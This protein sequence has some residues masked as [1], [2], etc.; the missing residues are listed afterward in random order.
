MCGVHV[1]SC[2]S[3]AQLF[4]TLWTVACQTLLSMGF[5]SQEYWSGLPFPPAWDLPDPEIKP[6]SLL[7]PALVG[8]FFTASATWETTQHFLVAEWCFPLEEPLWSH[9]HSVYFGWSWLPLDQGEH[10]TQTRPIRTSSLLARGIDG[11]LVTWPTS[12]SE[13]QWGLF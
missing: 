12:V 9:S 10:V 6:A 7:S 1:L 11:R 8:R 4:A 3:H 5:S 13:I 2:F